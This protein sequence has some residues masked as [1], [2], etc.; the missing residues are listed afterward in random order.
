MTAE[1]FRDA[2]IYEIYPQSYADSNGDGIG[3]LRGVIDRLEYI[4]SLGIDAIWFNPCFA[5]PFFDAGYDVADYLRIAPR[6][7]TNDDLVELVE[8]AGARGIR[9]LL[10]LVVGHTSIEHPWFQ[11]ELQAAGPSPEGDRYV[12]SEV[13]PAG[14]GIDLPGIPGWVKSPG[15]R[16]G[17]YLKNFY[18]EQPALNFGWVRTNPEQPWR[19]AIDAPGPMRNRAALQE[20]LDFWLRRGVAGFRVDMAFSLVKD[21]V[22]SDGHAASAAIWR[23][24]RAWLDTAYPD[25]V[26]IPEGEEPRLGEWLAFDADFTLVISAPHA[27]LFD[28]HSAGT[29]PWHTPREPFFAA[30]GQ[31]STDTFLATWNWLRSIDPDRPVILATADHDFNRLRCGGRTPEQLGAALTFLFTWGSIPSLYYGDEIGLRYLPD[32]PNVEGA[33]CNPSYNRAG[34]RTPM[35]W[36]DTANAGFST[37]PADQLYLPIDPDPSR[38]TVAGQ[39]GIPGSTLTLVRDLLALRRATPALQGHASTRVVHE[40]YPFA[41]VRGDSHLVAV[42]PRRESAAVDLAEFAEA[43]QVWGAGATIDAGRLTLDGFGYA[44][45]RR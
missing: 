42:N 30:E 25:A 28:D 18:E 41:Y 11:A 24:L 7:G 21:E 38:P 20:I 26:L 35:Q 8:K 44:I 4:A 37:A 10:D 31:G 45:L 29:L 27:S 3:D 34:C 43:T 17:W 40:G 32:M 6:Y 33:I 9:I 14:W 36:D 5:S 12:W 13:E 1:W 22:L 23:D 39:D 19:D 2:V 16:P 15:P